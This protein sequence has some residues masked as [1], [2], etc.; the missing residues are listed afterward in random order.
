MRHRAIDYV[1]RIRAAWNRAFDAIVETGRCLAEAKVELPHGEWGK[2]FEKRLLPFNV[3][4]AQCLMQIA[5]DRRIANHGSL[6]MPP[7]WRT[8][9]EISRLSDVDFLAAIASGAIHPTMTRTDVQIFRTGRHHA[10]QEARTDIVTDL[11][12][13]IAKGKT[14]GC[15][16]VDVPWPYGE[17]NGHYPLMSM[18]E[19]CALP[20][21]DV[22]AENCHLFMWV[23]APFFAKSFAV[24]DAWGFTYKSN[25]VWCKHPPAHGSYWMIVHEH[26]LLGVRGNLTSFQA[27]GGERER[28]WME[29]KKRAHSEKP[30]EVRAMI[31]RVSANPRLELFG[32]KRVKG[33]TVCG[34]DV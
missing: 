21:A 1:T 29:I 2:L 19:I 28:S 30:D 18:E 25:F 15:I 33:W 16:L 12:K 31:E 23:P 13:L 8:L 14:F 27:S 34:N 24:L 5:A 9:V 10:R 4:T 17:P 11:S 22:A 6:I 3:R 7:C 20:V 26:L 32:R